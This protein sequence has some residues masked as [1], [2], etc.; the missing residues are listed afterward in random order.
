M[1]AM[2][3]ANTFWGINI[4]KRKEKKRRDQT[5]N[6]HHALDERHS[7]AYDAAAVTWGSFDMSAK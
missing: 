6:I 3:C 1:P 5:N 7:F 4:K 2:T